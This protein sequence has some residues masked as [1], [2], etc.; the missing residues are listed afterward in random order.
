MA[1]VAILAAVPVLA[2]CGTTA[3]STRPVGVV[4]KPSTGAAP[5]RRR[6]AVLSA[7]AQGSDRRALLAALVRAGAPGAIALVRR[8]DR[9]QTLAGV[10]DV[11]S[12]ARMRAGLRFRVGSV[13]KR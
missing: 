1:C 11:E 10:A 8:G 4:S 9:I 5:V 13:S 2:A 3:V 12:G 6:A 7:A